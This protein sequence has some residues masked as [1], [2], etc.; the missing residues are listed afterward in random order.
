[1]RRVVFVNR[2][3]F[4]DH[5]ATS[6]ILSDLAFHLAG[7][8]REVHVLTSTQ[9]YDDPKASLP[10]SE[11]INDVHIHRIP[12]TRFGRSA[13]LGRSIDYLSFYRSLWRCLA[14]LT[15]QGDLIVAKTDPPLVSVVAM[16]VAHRKRAGLIN[17]LQD[18]YPEVAVQLGVPFIKG[19]LATGLTKMRNGSL[20]AGE[21][22][23]VV[24][25]LMWQKLEALGLPPANIYVIPNW[26]DDV[27]IHPLPKENVLRQAAELEDKFVFGYSGNL[28]RA[29]EFDTVLAAAELLRENPHIVFLMIGGGKKFDELA[30]LVQNR[31]LSRSFR[32]RPY[33]HHDL[34]GLSLGT[35]DVH[36]VS[37]N[38]KL[39]GYIFPSK[40]YGIAAAGKPI[41]VIGA[42]DGELAN[43]VRE[44]ECGVV[45]AQGDGAS[46]TAALLELAWKPETVSAMGKRARGML[47]ANF[48]R[49]K[50]LERWGSMLDQLD[51]MAL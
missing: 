48:S 36:W 35:A 39:E 44:Y 19:P 10:G 33:Q 37:L 6:Q 15:R 22:T 27:L 14:E 1:M 32:F 18:L 17:W 25:R 12:T 30:T 5:S 49:R 2:F 50:A 9:I 43:L 51:K 42:K 11:V 31:G 3:F 8:G 16:A 13:L 23:V 24:S 4:P 26:C 40:F 47:D 21:A 46:L 45:I 38:P 28:G 34:M 41:I 7:T 20:R 29:H